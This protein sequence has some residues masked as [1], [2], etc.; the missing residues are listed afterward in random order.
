MTLSRVM[1]QRALNGSTARIS[2]DFAKQITLATKGAVK[3]DQWAS[4]TAATNDVAA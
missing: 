2:V 3:W 1:V 4:D